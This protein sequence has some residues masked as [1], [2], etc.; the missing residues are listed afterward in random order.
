MNSFKH[1]AAN[2]R[3]SPD[4]RHKKT[5]IRYQSWLTGVFLGGGVYHA[6]LTARIQQ[7]PAQVNRGGADVVAATPAPVLRAAKVETWRCAFS[8]PHS[9]QATSSLLLAPTIFSNCAPHSLHLYSYNGIG[10]SVSYPLDDI[11]HA[12]RLESIANRR[13]CQG[14][15]VI[16]RKYVNP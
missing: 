11:C 14:V 2:Q 1:T 4:G 13:W 8:A 3:N 9:V 10:D 5:T 7:P 12:D 15:Y 6:G 16:I